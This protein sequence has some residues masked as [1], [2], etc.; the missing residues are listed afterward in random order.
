MYTITKPKI[1]FCDGQDYEKV[2]SATKDWQPEIVTT[3]GSVDGVL[4]IESLLDETKTE[5]S[6]Q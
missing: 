3:T 2:R 5:I 4:G 6:Y 1:V